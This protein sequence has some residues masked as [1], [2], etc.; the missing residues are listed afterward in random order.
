MTEETRCS[1]AA[2]DKG[3]Y[4]REWPSEPSNHEERGLLSVWTDCNC[5]SDSE[6][7]DDCDENYSLI[8]NNI[9]QAQTI[10]GTQRFVSG[11]ICSEDL[12]SPEIF[13]FNFSVS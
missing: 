6:S 10:R 4:H 3:L 1:L 9:V 2:S 5:N 13:G 12:K 7:P 8:P 11:N